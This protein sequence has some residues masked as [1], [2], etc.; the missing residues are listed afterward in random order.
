M[1]SSQT[2]RWSSTST[3]VASF[4]TPAGRPRASSVGLSYRRWSAMPATTRSSACR[5]TGFSPRS[6][7]CWTTRC[8][9]PPPPPRA[10]RASLNGRSLASR[11][12]PQRSSPRPYRR[13]GSTTTRGC[14]WCWHSSGRD[15]LPTAR[16]TDSSPCTTPSTRRSITTDELATTIRAVLKRGPDAGGPACRRIRLADYL[17]D[18]LRNAVAHAVRRV[19][20]PVLNPDD[21]ADRNTLDEASANVVRLL[22]RRV[23]DRWSRRGLGAVAV[24]I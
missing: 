12:T 16:S 24:A 22:R 5:R 8:R 20:R 23:S 6:P 2:T 1:R 9:S 3:V 18:A 10:T 7:S 4:G 21:L 17:W 19:G 13:S 11:D 15:A 14:D